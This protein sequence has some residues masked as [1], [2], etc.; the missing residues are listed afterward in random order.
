MIC[1]SIRVRVRGEFVGFKVHAS[2]QIFVPHLT[3]V[4]LLPVWDDRHGLNA[5]ALHDRRHD[6]PRL[7]I[8]G[9]DLRHSSRAH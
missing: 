3:C 4:T 9:G 6:V 8:G 5:D 1:R 7:V 2:R